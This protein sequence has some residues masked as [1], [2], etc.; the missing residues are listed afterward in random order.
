MHRRHKKQQHWLAM[1][2]RQPPEGFYRRP[3]IYQCGRRMEIEHFCAILAYDESH[4]CL[5]MPQ[6]RFTLYGDGLKIL[7]LTAGRLTVCGRFVRTDFSDD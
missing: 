5:Q 3:A 7:T 1:L 2:F 6:G 4:L